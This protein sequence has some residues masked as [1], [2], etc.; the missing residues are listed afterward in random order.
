MLDRAQP[1]DA[2]AINRRAV[3][4]VASSS[5][6]YRWA[7]RPPG[8]R[9]LSLVNP[10]L[11]RSRSKPRRGRPA[12]RNCSEFR[13]PSPHEIDG[14]PGEW[15]DLGTGE[16]VIRTLWPNRVS[17]STDRRTAAEFLRDLTDR[18]WR[19]PRD[20]RRSH[21]ETIGQLHA[22]ASGAPASAWGCGSSRPTRSRA[23]Q[24]DMSERSNVACR[25]AGR[26]EPAD[27]AWRA[28]TCDLL[29]APRR[30]PRR[31]A[32]GRQR[33]PRAP[34]STLWR[35][36]SMDTNSRTPPATPEATMA[37]RTRN[38]GATSPGSS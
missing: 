11:C 33:G 18:L 36:K 24:S 3:Q 19:S 20:R 9:N 30:Q 16:G 27:V 26:S 12:R 34:R 31:R 5:A 2:R 23:D 15:R 7:E 13:G 29:L 4:T 25:E 1:F 10:N 6:S 8:W 35:L 37:A 17:G 38:A 28:S 14:G 22:S 21:A 32:A